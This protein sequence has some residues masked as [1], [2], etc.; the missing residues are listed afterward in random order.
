MTLHII[1]LV[2]DENLTV[3]TLASLVCGHNDLVEVHRDLLGAAF[4]GREYIEAATVV[5]TLSSILSGFPGADPRTVRMVME[6][7]VTGLRRGPLAMVEHYRRFDEATGWLDN[8]RIQK[9]AADAEAAHC[10]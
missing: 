9:R 7:V 4:R 3:G 8:L 5:N 10:G 6:S 2:D 1:D